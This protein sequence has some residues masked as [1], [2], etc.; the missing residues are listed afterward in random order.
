MDMLYFYYIFTG[1][2]DNL[3][4]VVMWVFIHHVFRWISLQQ[5]LAIF[6]SKLEIK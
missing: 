6:C 4:S 5:Y 3:C 2:Y 1:S